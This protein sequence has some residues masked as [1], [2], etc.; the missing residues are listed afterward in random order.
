MN[1]LL[2]IFMEIEDKKCLVVG[3][4][5]IALHKIEQLIDSQAQVTVISPEI[6]KSIKA[7]PVNLINRE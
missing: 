6:I 5:K 7:L 3:G 1:N 2:P 4:G